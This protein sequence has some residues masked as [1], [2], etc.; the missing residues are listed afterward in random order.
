MRAYVIKNNGNSNNL[1]CY[2]YHNVK[3]W[4]HPNTLQLLVNK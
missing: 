2:Q 4:Y 3:C 1:P